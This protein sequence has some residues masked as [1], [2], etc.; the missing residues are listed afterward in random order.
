MTAI[1]AQLAS[2]D[3]ERNKGTTVRV[4]SLQEAAYG[5]LRSP[6]LLLQGAVGFVLLIGCANVAGLMLARPASRRTEIAIRTAL[7]AGR[8][9]IIWQ[10]VTESAPLAILGGILGVFLAWGGLSYFWQ[11]RLRVPQDARYLVGRPGTGIYGA[12]RDLNRGGFRTRP[13]HPSVQARFGG[14]T[15]GIRAGRQL[16]IGAGLMINSFLRVQHK[17]LG[18]IPKAC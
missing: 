1:A 12:H 17:D 5:D 10:L 7:G 3:P 2:G 16:L 9:R 18:R 4:Q 13:R 11:R 15:E 14:L 8:G 6:L